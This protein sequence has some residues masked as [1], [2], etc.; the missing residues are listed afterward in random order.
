MAHDANA[1]QSGQTPPSLSVVIPT[2]GRPIAAQTV[3]SL[4]AT[5]LASDLEVILVGQRTGPAAWAGI[6]AASKK[7]GNFNHLDVSFPS[8]DSSRKKNAGLAASRAPIVAFLDDDVKVPPD[9]PERVLEVFSGA[10][11]KPRPGMMSGPSIMPDNIPLMARLCGGALASGAAGYVSERYRGGSREPRPIKWSGI[12]GCNMAF[13]RQVI[14]QVKGFDPKFWPGEEMLAAYRV[15]RAGHA[16]VF[17]PNAPVFHYPR[18]TFKGF[19]RQIFGYG[20]TRIRLVR[21]G[22]EIE[23]STF[24]PAILVAGAA[25]LGVA[26]FFSAWAARLLAAAAAVYFV[27]ALA[28]AFRMF[29]RSRQASDLLVA[30]IIPLMHLAY[31]VAEWTEIVLPGRDLSERQAGHG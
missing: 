24:V 28:A 26:S 2:L 31:G 29:L 12:I 23:A 6:E 19:F 4:A 11:G 5:G 18:G 8:G 13:P 15:E 27:M 21:A 25:A 10:P 17:H 14:E 30:F 20:A 16:I 9:W 22:V 1:E 7:L 3:E